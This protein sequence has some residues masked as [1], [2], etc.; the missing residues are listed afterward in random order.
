MTKENKNKNLKIDLMHPIDDAL[1]KNLQVEKENYVAPRSSKLPLGLAEKIITNLTETSDLDNPQQALVMLAMLFQQGGTAR[2]CDGNMAVTFQGKT[3]KLADVRK[4]LKANSCNKGER[5]LARTLADRI[6][7][8]A[9][10]MEIPGNLSKKT[11]RQN[12][13]QK[14]EMKDKVWLS[15]FQSDNENCPIEL[16]K[17]IQETFK[18]PIGKKKKKL[19]RKKP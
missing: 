18:K 14:F 12:L 17:L 10:S 1:K 7:E 19:K 13:D 11:Q 3:I 8:I 5:K 15:D 4:V 9:V 6:Y 2:S 16:R